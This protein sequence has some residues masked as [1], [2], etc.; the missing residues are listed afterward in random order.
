MHF[1][2]AYR[3]NLPGQSSI[4]LEAVVTSFLCS[5]MCLYVLVFV[6][7]ERGVQLHKQFLE[8]CGFGRYIHLFNCVWPSLERQGAMLHSVKVSCFFN[9]QDTE[10]KTIPSQSPTEVLT[11]LFRK[12][13]F[14]VSKV[15]SEENHSE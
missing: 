4:A 6:T 3:R 14:T 1:R 10:R 13:C 11:D 5:V 15:M 9:S 2:F 8:R 12:Q 7:K